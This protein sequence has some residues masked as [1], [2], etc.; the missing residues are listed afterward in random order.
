MWGCPGVPRLPGATTR[1]RQAGNPVR[2]SFSPRPPRLDAA[3]LIHFTVLPGFMGSGRSVAISGM[4]TLLFFGLFAGINYA[5]VFYRQAVERARAVEQVRAELAQAELRTLRAQIHPH[6]LFNTLNSIASLIRA[7][8][9]AAEE[10]TT[11][12][13]RFF[14]MRS[15]APS[16]NA[17]R[18]AR[19]EFVRATSDR[20][21]AFGSGCA[22]KRRSARGRRPSG[23]QPP[24]RRS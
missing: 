11:P 1:P 23:Y 18:S 4:Y 16:A 8:P 5:I 10:M 24:A 9:D 21:H 17:Y 7:N 15:R 6:F 22:W 2:L 3:F 14:D 19:A 20:A 12:W 13:T